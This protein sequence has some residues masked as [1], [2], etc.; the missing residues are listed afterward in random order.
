MV[1][2]VL[3]LLEM[4]NRIALLFEL[5]VGGVGTGCVGVGGVGVGGVGHWTGAGAGGGGALVGEP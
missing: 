2:R 5:G 4:M 3:P 1:W